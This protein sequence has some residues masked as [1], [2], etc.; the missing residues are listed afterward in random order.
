M[1]FSRYIHQGWELLLD[2]PNPIIHDFA[3][4]PQASAPL[5]PQHDTNIWKLRMHMGGQEQ[6]FGHNTNHIPTGSCL[7]DSDYRHCIVYKA[8]DHFLKQP[9]SSLFSLCPDDNFQACE[10]D[11]PIS[12]VANPRLNGVE[13]HP[14]VASDVDKSNQYVDGVEI[15]EFQSKKLSN[16]YFSFV[17]DVGHQIVD[18]CPGKQ[19]GTEAYG[20]HSFPP[21][22][23]TI[24]ARLKGHSLTVNSA[25][26]SPDGAQ[27][28]SASDD[29][30]ARVWD[31]RFGG[32]QKLKL[33]HPGIV[34]SAL[35]SSDG[36]LI[37]TACTD[38]IE[39][40]EG[41]VRVWDAEN[42]K[43]KSELHL[44]KD[45]GAPKRAGFSSSGDL[46]VVACNGGIA[47]V[48]NWVDKTVKHSLDHLKMPVNDAAFSPNDGTIVTAC[49]DGKA[50]V[51]NAN[52]GQL[53]KTIDHGAEV[54]TT[55]YSHSG[56]RIVTSC[57]DGKARVWD[58]NVSEGYVERLTFDHE[59]TFHGIN[60]TLS[61]TY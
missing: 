23:G 49:V 34:N 27:I 46:I 25:C 32:K 29:K 37:V 52:T 4:N 59:D 55:T 14:T 61:I 50:R 11:M 2:T 54:C 30:T 56:L 19:I 5:I 12:K 41:K 58:R 20:D 15:D 3:S 53:E 44:S 16:Y 6:Q 39:G 28:V 38:G 9:E 10:T 33:L 40:K 60:W 26:F 35:F 1:P 36:K 31:T 18:E 47:R 7:N 57:K 51:W 22:R 42:G 21:D 17:K 8:K 48:W 43:L 13:E 24:V 45:I